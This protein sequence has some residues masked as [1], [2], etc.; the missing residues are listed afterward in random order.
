MPGSAVNPRPA[1]LAAV[2]AA[3][4]ASGCTAVGPDFQRPDVPWLE[5]W[6]GGSPELTAAI[7]AVGA[8]GAG[9]RVVAGLQ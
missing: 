7:A 9:R 3:L 6:R 4:L 1:R 8:A 5:D 2:L